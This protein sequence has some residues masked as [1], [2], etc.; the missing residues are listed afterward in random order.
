[1]STSWASSPLE[2]LHKSRENIKTH[3]KLSKYCGC[4]CSCII[5]CLQFINRDNYQ[6]RFAVLFISFTEFVGCVPPFRLIQFIKFHL[7]LLKPLNVLV[8]YFGDCAQYPARSIIFAP[9]ALLYIFIIPSFP[10]LPIVGTCKIA[11]PASDSNCHLWK[12]FFGQSGH[13]SHVL[14]YPHSFLLLRIQS[15]CIIYSV[16]CPSGFSLNIILIPCHLLFIA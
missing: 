12:H 2:Q 3:H 10:I 9:H 16:S 6:F 15:L 11:Q 5:I 13:Q 7:L 14:S 4:R 8:Y 1:M